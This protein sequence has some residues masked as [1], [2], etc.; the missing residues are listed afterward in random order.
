MN[1]GEVAAP[2]ARDQN[3]PPRL[4]VVFQQSHTPTALSSDRSAHQASRTR[5][6]NNHV[7][8]SRRGRHASIVADSSRHRCRLHFVVAEHRMRN[9]PTVVLLMGSVETGLD[10]AMTEWIEIRHL[11][12]L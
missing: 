12:R 4:S 10:D 11:K 5:A 2:A 1:V 3:L 9:Q 8:G 6:K 7:E